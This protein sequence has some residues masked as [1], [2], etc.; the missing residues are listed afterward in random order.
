MKPVFLSLLLVTLT[1]CSKEENHIQAKIRTLRHGMSMREV[2]ELLGKP[3]FIDTP[4][5]HRFGTW[6]AGISEIWEYWGD[7]QGKPLPRY[8]GKR[9]ADAC[10]DD[11][12][13][14]QYVWAGYEPIVAPVR[15]PIDKNL[16]GHFQNILLETYKLKAEQGELVRPATHDSLW[17][18][19]LPTAYVYPYYSNDV[20]TVGIE[21]RTASSN[22]I[23]YVAELSREPDPWKRTWTFKFNAAL[24]PQGNMLRNQ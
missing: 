17:F 11:A 7:D 15:Y 10:F 24:D 8:T 16:V 21:V 19:P 13:K 5:N 9:H 22:R 14:L 6:L 18:S 23:T 20:Y 12:G 1:G 2:E 4:A 3:S